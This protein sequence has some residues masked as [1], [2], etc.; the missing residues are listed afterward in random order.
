M[1]VDCY[2]AQAAKGGE[3]FSLFVA[4]VDAAAAGDGDERKEG[5]DEQ[6]EEEEDVEGSPSSACSAYGFQLVSPVEFNG[7]RCSVLAGVF[8]VF[9]DRSL[10][11][12]KHSIGSKRA[13]IYLRGCLAVV[14]L[15]LL[16]RSDQKPHTLLRRNT[17]A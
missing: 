8:V 4:V 5:E 1:G 16:R 12:C 17:L 15:M 7:S 3:S 6:E 9:I 10:T 11:L 2:G 14:V 13:C